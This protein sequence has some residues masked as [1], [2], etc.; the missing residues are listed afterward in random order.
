MPTGPDGK[1]TTARKRKTKNEEK[2]K[3]KRHDDSMNKFDVYPL[4]GAHSLKKIKE[5]C[6]PLRV[7]ACH[8]TRERT[9]MKCFL[10]R[11][12]QEEEEE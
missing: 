8:R 7:V 12:F 6:E 11:K 10:K 2:K 3:T 1:T 4:Y 9:G 5:V